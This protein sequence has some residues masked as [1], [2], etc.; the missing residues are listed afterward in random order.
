MKDLKAVM[1]NM[2]SNMQ[3]TH[4]TNQQNELL[5]KQVSE[6]AKSV[7][8]DLFNE[9][10]SCYPAWKQAFDNRE[11]WN[12]AKKTWT[13][14]FIENNISNQH[15]VSLGLAAARKGDNPFWP[16]VGQFINWCDGPE[17]DTDEA[18]NR[19]I[20]H[21]P[22]VGVAEYET[23]QEV[24]FRC[25][26]QL[27]EDKARALFKKVLTRNIQRVKNGELV[28]PEVIAKRVEAPEEFRNRETPE[29]RNIRLDAEIAAMQASGTRLI[30][31]YKKRFLELRGK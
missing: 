30:G 26:Q 23:R 6:N 29:Q 20:D 21:K 3:Q 7:I 1:Q 16:S 15:Q 14:A 11:A 28:E 19:M 27:S 24:G 31:P 25:K 17:I 18:F 2:Q 10:K 5:K 4:I 13:K 8:D 9:L 22:Y 12:A